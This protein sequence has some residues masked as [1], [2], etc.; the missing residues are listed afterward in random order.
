MPDGS[1]PGSLGFDAAGLRSGTLVDMTVDAAR[2][3][4]TPNAY[5]YGA[6]V[7]HGLQNM[8]LWARGDTAW[9]KLDSVTPSGA[10]LW[11]G[12]HL[13][14]AANLGYLGISNK[15]LM[16][17]W[18]DGEVWLDASSTETFMISGDDVTFVE[19]ALP[20]S[21]SY[22]L[23]TDQNATVSVPTPMTGWYPIHVGDGN[24]S[25]GSDLQ[26]QH[27]DGGSGGAVP[28]TRD[29]LR[30]RTSEL[31]GVLRTVYGHQILGG[32]QAVGGSPPPIAHFEQSSLLADTMFLTAPQGAD[33]DNNDWSA[34][35]VGQV[36]IDQMGA[37]TLTI[38]SDDGNRGRLGASRGEALWTRDVGVGQNDALTTIQ[39]NLVSGWN[40]L[41]IDYNQVN[42][43]RDL[44]VQLQ[45]PDFPTAIDVPRDR[46][47]SVESADD[48]LALG[49]D[50]GNHNVPD[51]GGPGNPG[52]AT[53]TV[54]A[55]ADAQ[56][57]TETVSSIDVT[58]QINSPH[59]NQL[60]VDLQ[61][62]GGAPV[63]IR[64][65][66][67]P[68]NNVEGRAIAA[69]TLTGDGLGALL[70]AAANGDWK[71]HVYDDMATGGNS[72]LESARLTLHMTGGPDKVAK[73]A[74]WTSRVID[75]TTPVTA[76]HGITWNERAPTGATVQV[77]FRA[78]QQADC[79]DGPA[80]SGPVTSGALFTIAPARYLQLR[81]VMTSD[82]NHEP[83]LQSL[84]ITFGGG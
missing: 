46:L 18:F 61:A 79:S 47:R 36:H 15:G 30:A 76:I 2:G 80:F 67:G 45:G 81:V 52:T 31:S 44:S 58:Y 1:G 10:G 77:Q 3:A 5:S 35:Y 54:A 82:G 56:L 83:E 43:G 53:L 73:A 8:R 66:V 62:P 12:E 14:N 60:K 57:G 48:R 6:L 9:S 24:A 75:T 84:A 19:I 42:G 51:N 16:T 37:Y 28:W 27:S 11:T 13:T 64:D 17:I 26:F 22:T 49:V 74:S 29:R 32:G 63:V 68:P 41:S 59:W 25:G 20:G 38:H 7:A 39:A 21:T 23:L 55:Y 34:R 40:D 72:A 65:H 78:C 4:L 71:L 50:D 69:Q 70:G 33:G